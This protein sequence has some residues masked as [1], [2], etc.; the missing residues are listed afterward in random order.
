MEGWVVRQ[1]S[2]L[3]EDYSETAGF[4]VRCITSYVD[5]MLQGGEGHVGIEQGGGRWEMSECPEGGV[6]GAGVSESSKRLQL[7]LQGFKL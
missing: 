1:W 7:F 4:S 5:K 6:D 3:T 2:D